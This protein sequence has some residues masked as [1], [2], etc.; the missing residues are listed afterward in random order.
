M[1]VQGYRIEFRCATLAEAHGAAVLEAVREQLEVC[2][3]E[4]GSF[5]LFEKRVKGWVEVIVR[6]P[7]DG[8]GPRL[9]LDNDKLRPHVTVDLDIASCVLNVYVGCG[10]TVALEGNT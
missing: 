5:G 8:R 2:V 4:P 1:K 10:G 6:R 7:V 9:V 3:I